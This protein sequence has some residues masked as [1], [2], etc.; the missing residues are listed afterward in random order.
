MMRIMIK[1]ESAWLPNRITAGMKMKPDC[2]FYK[3]LYFQ[4]EALIQ[5][6]LLVSGYANWRSHNCSL[7]HWS[8]KLRV[9]HA[10]EI[11]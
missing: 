7:D 10:P 11:R 8:K 5:G 3:S 1:T 2:T 6:V 4:A 9:L